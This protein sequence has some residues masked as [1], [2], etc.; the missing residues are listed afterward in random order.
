VHAKT[1]KLAKTA[2][3]VW[4]AW[5]S[6]RSVRGRMMAAAG[7]RQRMA[8]PQS[9]LRH[10]A[11]LRSGALCC[12]GHCRLASRVCGEG[13]AVASRIA[14][15]V[16]HGKLVRRHCDEAAH[17]N[18]APQAMLYRAMVAAFRLAH[19]RHTHR[20]RHWACNRTKVHGIASRFS[21]ARQAAHG[22]KSLWLLAMCGRSDQF[23]GHARPPSRSRSC[24]RPIG[25]LAQCRVLGRNCRRVAAHPGHLEA[26]WPPW[27]ASW[28]RGGCAG[29]PADDDRP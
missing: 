25:R 16:Q 2:V 27:G 17:P 7:R 13:G 18:R 4:L 11:R 3:L 9:I 19:D 14:P 20:A 8:A 22:P 5:L 24:P 26:G 21:P 12:R 28:E 29:P 1:R 23:L 6:V 15:C 10:R